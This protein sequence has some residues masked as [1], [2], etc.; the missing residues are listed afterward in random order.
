MTERRTYELKQ[1]AEAVAQTRLRITEA[2]LALHQEVGPAYTTVAD[3]AR[4]AGVDRVTVYRHFP[5]NAA[6]FKACS[7]HFAAANP[8]PDPDAWARIADPRERL[9]HGLRSVY[10]YYARAEPLLANVM[11]DAEVMPEVREA[12]SYRRQWLRRVEEQL[13]AGWAGDAAQVR[14]AVGLAIDFRTWQ[15]LVRRRGLS[16]RRAVALMLEMVGGVACT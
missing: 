11:R 15:T 4:L 3:I 6:L 10:G 5:D 16:R 9:G 8:L 12:G 7:S 1:R 13:A 14:H 2:A